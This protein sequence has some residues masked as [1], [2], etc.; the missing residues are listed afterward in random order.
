M[1]IPIGHSP[2]VLAF[3]KVMAFGFQEAFGQNFGWLNE[4]PTNTRDEG[5]SVIECCVYPLPADGRALGVGVTSIVGNVLMINDCS[6]A[7]VDTATSAV[8]MF[9]VDK[10]SM[11][12]TVVVSAL[13]DVV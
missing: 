2:I 7:S 5:E 8:A 4:T 1:K 13:T 6:E 12:S 11:V 10:S 9:S 3:A